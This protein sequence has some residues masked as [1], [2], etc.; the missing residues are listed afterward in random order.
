MTITDIPTIDGRF[1]REET[2]IPMTR[3]EF[4]QWVG[5]RKAE[6]AY[7]EAIF[8]APDNTS[9]SSLN[10]WLGRVLGDFAE[11]KGL[12]EVFID[13]MEAQLESTDRQPDILFVSND[14]RHLIGRIYCEGAPDLAVEVVSPNSA[15]RDYHEKFAEY[16]ASGVR[17]YW[18]IDPQKQTIHAHRLL[19]SAYTIIPEEN[20]KIASDVLPGFYLRGE[21]LWK[22][23]RPWV[24]TVLKE[25]GVTA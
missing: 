2:H 15:K 24:I 1:A 5:E 6:W 25:L 14:R 16:A 22:S 21:W 13:C 8:M 7:G 4:Y 17:E 23:P 12:G 19:G 11:A 10:S 20:G 9:H 18:I 3:E